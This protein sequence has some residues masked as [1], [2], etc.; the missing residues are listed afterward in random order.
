MFKLNLNGHAIGSNRT[1]I[2]G[3][4]I[5]LLAWILTIVLAAN[6]L[7]TTGRNLYLKLSADK[8]ILTS[9][10]PNCGLHWAFKIISFWEQ[11]GRGAKWTNIHHISKAGDNVT[12]LGILG[13]MVLSWLI[14]GFLIF[15]L[16]AINP[17]QL[18]VPKSPFFLFRRTYWCPNDAKDIDSS[19]TNALSTTKENRDLGEMFERPGLNVG[20]AV[21]VLRSVT[22]QFNKAKKKAID[23]LSLE[24]YRDQITVI[25]GHN[26]A[27]K[28]TMMNLLTGLFLP[29]HGEMFINGYSVT[30]NTI[31]ARR[32]VGLCPQHNVLFGELTVEEHLYFFAQIK[33]ADKEE[34]KS[35]IEVIL[36]K[37]DLSGKRYVL[38]RDLS[39]GMKRKLCMANAM[40]GGSNILVLDEP[41]AGMDPQARR[42]IWTVLQEVRRTRTIL[43]TTHYMEEADVLGDRI[44][45][46]SHG[47]LKCAGSP[48]FLKKKFGKFVA[49]SRTR[50]RIAFDVNRMGMSSLA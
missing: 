29:T 49:V 27:G 23:N 20:D 47:K 33:G 18:G 44:A 8:K 13:M 48:M 25:L 31:K 41:T 1:A 16:D 7:D 45:F 40:V 9:L 38:S 6:L 3:A 11:S 50:R 21:V 14:F 39:G 17:W 32:G 37:F 46:L 43:L 26:G 5:A 28:T 4:I 12:L 2:L 42:S 30:E 15:Y 34:T 36:S 10:L 22:H 19:R 24:I 35:E